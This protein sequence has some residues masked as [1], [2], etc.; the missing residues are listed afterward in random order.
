MVAASS[1]WVMPCSTRGSRITDSAAPTSRMISISSRRRCNTRVVAV[2]TVRIAASP[3]TAPTPRPTSWKRWRN[4]ARPS[5]HCAPPCTS[6]ISGSSARRRTSARLPSGVAVFASGVTSTEAGS[7][8]RGSWS[9]T[10]AW[11]PSARFSECIES[12][13][14]D[15]RALPHR[16]GAAIDLAQEVAQL[17]GRWF[18]LQVDDHADPIAPLIDGAPEVQREEPEAAQRRQRQRDEEHR[19]HT[20]PA[21]PAEVP[22]RLGDDEAEHHPSSFSRWPPA[23]VSLRPLSWVATRA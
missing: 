15:A 23:S 4:W 2:V 10:S 19:A 6:S 12:G 16:D 14:L 22:Q 11:A 7:G 1:P 9:V 21:R 13:E 18:L 20:D 5:T 3:S 8:F 17:R